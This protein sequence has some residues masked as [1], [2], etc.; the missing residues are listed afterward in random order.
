MHPPTLNSHRPV[1]SFEMQLKKSGMEITQDAISSYWAILCRKNVNLLTQ[2][3]NI[4]GAHAIKAVA[5][6]E[7]EFAGSENNPFTR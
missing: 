4:T 1:T 6:R 3:S 5:S 2:G 7:A